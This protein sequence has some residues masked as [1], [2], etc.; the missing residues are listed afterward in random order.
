MKNFNFSYDEESDDLFAYMPEKKSKGAV[1]LGNFILD[2]D[3]KGNLVAMQ[4]L[5]ASK[6]L[7]K[8][9]SKMI[10]LA[11]IKEIKVEIINFR[12]MDAVKF[13]IISDSEEATAN[14]LVPHIMERS[15]V[16]EY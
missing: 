10:K 13:K 14:I 2:F 5:D 8:V 4:I 3:E 9:L 11:K 15:P 16:L 6:F 12:N 1:E 7:A